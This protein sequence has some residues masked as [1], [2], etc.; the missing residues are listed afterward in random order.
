MIY[1]KIIDIQDSYS[2]LGIVFNYNGNFCTARKKL[3]EQAQKSMYAL[4]KKIKNIS[5]PVDLQLKLFDS[6]VA[7]VLLYAS[8]IWGFENK[9]SIERVHLQFCKSILKVRDSTPNFLVC[10]ELGRFPLDNDFVSE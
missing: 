8:E 2:Y 7:P 5:F 3:L 6:L 9:N 4:Y 10:G 1:D